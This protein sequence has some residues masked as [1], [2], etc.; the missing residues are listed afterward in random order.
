MREHG[1]FT[2]LEALVAIVVLSIGLLGLAALQATA[3]SFNSSAYQ[4]SQATYLAYDILDRMRANLCRARA[5][6]Y[7]LTLADD[8][9]TD[10]TLAATDL[11]EWRRA[12]GNLLPSGT[13]S[14]ARNGNIVTITIQWDDSRGQNPVQ[15]FSTTTQ[16]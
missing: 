5:G 9:P 7:D 8:V 15:Q 14:I 16:L 3:L 11:R 12:A 10:T 4:R 13:G 6:D 1:G 2:L